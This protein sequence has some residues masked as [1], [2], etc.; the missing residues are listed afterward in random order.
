MLLPLR[1]TVSQRTV[2]LRIFTKTIKTIGVT[3][4][5]AKALQS[6]IVEAIRDGKSHEEQVAPNT[7][8]TVELGEYDYMSA[9][10]RRYREGR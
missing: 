6:M 1:K 2:L 7:F 3:E 5:E 8:I 10:E 4:Y 9:R